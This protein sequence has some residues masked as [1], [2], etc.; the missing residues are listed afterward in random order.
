MAVLNLNQLE[1]QTSR[2]T[3]ELPSIYFFDSL[4]GYHDKEK[5]VSDLR[6]FLVFHWKQQFPDRNGISDSYFNFRACKVQY[7]QFHGNTFHN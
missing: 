7:V 6:K 5:Y 4:G 2:S 3:M 1:V